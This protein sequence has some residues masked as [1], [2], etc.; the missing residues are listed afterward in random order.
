MKLLH[1]GDLHLDS[2]FSALSVEEAQERRQ[3]QRRLLK[4]IF[5][6]AREEHCDLIL[7]AGDLFD[8]QYVTPETDKLLR[9]LLSETSCHVII[10][11][12]NHDPYTEGSFYKKT[13]LPE[14]VHVFRSPMLSFVDFPQWNTRVYGY[15]F[16][17]P[18]LKD[19]PLNIAEPP[20]NSMGIHLLCAHGELGDPLSKY[21]PIME[22]DIEKFDIKYAAL[23]HVHK[24]PEPVRT[25]KGQIAYCGVPE[26]R[27]FDE[28]GECG[29][30]L[31]TVEED[32]PIHCEKRILAERRYHTAELDVSAFGTEGE[33]LAAIEKEASM[34]ASE[35][36][37]HLRIRL[38]GYM[39]PRI[40]FAELVSSNRRVLLCNETLPTIDGETLKQDVTIRG[41]LYRTLYP[42]LISGDREVRLRAIRALRIGLAAID[43]REIPTEEEL[44]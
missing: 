17:S 39:D 10:S 21:A 26:G 3:G 44:I 12:G 37:M 1:T 4:R 32:G 8:H 9:T 2:P 14:H 40:S 34:W 29:V 25:P 28:T 41:A 27:S 35:T 22:S 42:S 6:C 33:I 18:S 38:T 19:S 43:E 36:G 5:D 7:I 13:T 24:R 15:A 16:V 20:Q 23:G 11:P 30:W 31:V